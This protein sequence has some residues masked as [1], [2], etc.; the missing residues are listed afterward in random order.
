MP[1][2]R[3]HIHTTRKTKKK[4]NTCISYDDILK[5]ISI[6]HSSSRAQRSPACSIPLTFLKFCTNSVK[7][8]FQRNQSCN[9][10]LCDEKWKASSKSRPQDEGKL[11]WQIQFEETEFVRAVVCVFEASFTRIAWSEADAWT[12]EHSELGSKTTQLVC[13]PHWTS[14]DQCTMKDGW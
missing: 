3:T 6:R 4:K 2:P 5:E 8:K 1:K 7:K 12:G 10:D 11:A 9:C 14:T 13:G